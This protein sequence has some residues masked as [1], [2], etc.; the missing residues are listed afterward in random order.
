MSN[1]AKSFMIVDD[2]EKFSIFWQVAA[3][4]AS[5]ECKVK[6]C[7]N[8][9][10]ALEE[11]KEGR[12]DF[13]IAGWEMQPM[14]GLIFMQ[15]L[16]Q[17]FKYRRTPF[18]IFSKTLEE[19]HLSLAREFGI[20]NYLLK[21]FDKEK[22][23]QKISQMMAAEANLDNTQRTLRR[24]EDWIGENRI[25]EALKI[26]TDVLK[27]GPH[28][29]RAYTLCGDLWSKTEHADR[30]EK[31]YE[32]ALKFDSNYTP[33]IQGRAKLLMKLRRFD[34]AVKALEEL[35]RRSPGNLNRMINLGDAYLGTGNTKKAE[36]IFNNVKQNDAESGDGDAGLGKV[37]FQKGNMELAAKFFKE[38]GKGGEL[39]TYF[40]SMGIAMVNTGK[41]E[42]AIKLY[43]NA[44]NVLPDLNRAHL[45]EFN[46]GLA[47]RKSS[48]LGEATEAFARSVILSPQYEKAYQGMALCMR[49][50]QEKSQTFNK[51]LIQKAAKAF[52]EAKESQDSHP[53]STST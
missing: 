12:Y 22:V 18:L 40:N 17:V 10:E 28:A 16:R 27:P 20:D 53:T 47:F 26:I 11:C 8:G 5:P 24:I 49:E 41:Y 25:N 43:T 51:A 52:R 36:S 37:E 23:T 48:R 30:A 9:F 13:F 31:A 44:I 4:E 15:K 45:L 7:K 19:Q 50:A 14:S 35:D 21:P 1:E 33:A 38:S 34:E 32:D 39:A 42:D 2:D 46:I 29:S 6:I 3:N